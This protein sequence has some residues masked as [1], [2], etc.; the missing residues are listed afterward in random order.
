MS[1]SVLSLLL[2]M[3]CN[4]IQ[5][6]AKGGEHSQ[7]SQFPECRY[8]RELLIVKTRNGME[9]DTARGKER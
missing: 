4:L 9:F 5:P 6:D 8:V 2:E 3:E 7:F 1:E